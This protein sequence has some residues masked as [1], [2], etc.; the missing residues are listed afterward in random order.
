MNISYHIIHVS[1]MKDRSIHESL[2]KSLR[3]VVLPGKT[4]VCVQPRD[5]ETLN[6]G[7]VLVKLCPR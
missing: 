3:G 1:C 5:D 2:E 4:G 7:L 6:R